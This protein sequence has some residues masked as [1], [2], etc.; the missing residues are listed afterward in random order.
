MD[1]VYIYMEKKEYGWLL[2]IDIR[3][4]KFIMYKDY[5]IFKRVKYEDII[6]NIQTCI[7]NIFNPCYTRQYADDG[8]NLSWQ[9]YTFTFEKVIGFQF[10]FYDSLD[11]LFKKLNSCRYINHP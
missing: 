9:S 3:I 1:Y 8:W 11:I 7:L 10:D 2:K 5:K 4:A 6:S